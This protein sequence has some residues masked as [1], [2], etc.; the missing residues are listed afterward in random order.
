MAWYTDVQH[1]VKPI[2]SGY[3]LALSYNLVHVTPGVPPPIL[4]DMHS[5]IISLRRV[6]KKWRTYKYPDI[7]PNIMCHI[8]SHKYSPAGLSTGFKALKGK[9]SYLV[10][11]LMPLAAEQEFFV[12]LANL[13][14]HQT[15]TADGD[16]GY[17]NYYKRRRGYG[18]YGYGR[19]GY[20]GD[21]DCDDDDDEE[22][23]GIDEVIDTTLTVDN[24]FDMAGNKPAGSK[25]ISL[26]LE[27]L[28]QQDAF[29]DVEPDEDHYEGYM[30][31]Y[32]GEVEQCKSFI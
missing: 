23:P 27:N 6:L 8:L 22:V 5:S 20:Y 1:E 3:R 31:N 28:V 15:G 21:S 18:R 25:K 29:E 12:G 2:T 11:Q 26:D 14:Y 4:P 13:M 9:D 30:G 16:G 32:S 24:L 10:A 7:E 19:Y 17:G